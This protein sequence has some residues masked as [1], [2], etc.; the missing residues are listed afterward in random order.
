MSIGEPRRP[1][2]PVGRPLS[3]Y[4]TLGF[5]VVGVGL[6]L[7][8]LLTLSG[9]GGGTHAAATNTRQDDP[10]EEARDTLDHS[11]DVS[12]CRAALQKINLAL[13]REVVPRA[14]PLDPKEG[15][16]LQKDFN[17]SKEE[18]EEISAEN[19]TLLDG[20]HLDGAFLLHDAATH[21]LEPEEVGGDLPAPSPLERATAA[22]AWVMREVRLAEPTPVGLT[23]PQFALRRA[24]GT[25]LERALVYLELLDQLGAA[26]DEAAAKP[27]QAE[28]PPLLGCLIFCRDKPAD[29][30]RLWACGVVLNGGPD[31]YLFDPRLGLPLPGANGKSVATL[32]EVCKDASLLKQLDVDAAHPYDVTTEQA[33]TAELHLVCSLSSLAPRMAHLQKKLL[34]PVRVSL[35]HDLNGEL[36]IW[37]NAA[38]KTEGVSPP[39][40]VWAEGAGVLRRFLPADDGGADPGW[41]GGFPLAALVGFTNPND[42]SKVQMQRL[43]LFRLQMA[44]WD[45]MPAQFHDM[46]K[47]PYNVGLGLRV[48]EGFLAPFAHMMAEPQ[49]PRDRMLRGEFDKAAGD[50]VGMSARMRLHLD[51]REAAGTAGELE[52]DV[53]A[54]VDKA[55]HAYAD[56]LRAQEKGSP[57]AVE[58]ATREVDAIWKE[59]TPVVTLL[60][61]ASAVPGLADA[62][63]LLGLCKHEKAEQSQTRLDLLARS[64]GDKAKESDRLKDARQDAR[65]AWID[66]LGWWKKYGDDHPEESPQRPSSSPGR[67]AAVRQM[68]ARAQAMLGDDKAAQT[69]Y[70][71]LTEPMAPLEKVAALYRARRMKR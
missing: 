33:R 53:D 21:A 3:F 22:F 5:L 44:P 4:I 16:R 7:M 34:P 58:A 71:D 64:L 66:A 70:E 29:A 47:F 20:Q 27:G 25:P 40:K 59:A 43:Q 32:A 42:P 46:E 26:D 36:Q 41:P 8:I 24:T 69:T 15:E 2:E 50:L 12:A 31:V 49:S 62:T 17:L 18:I 55:R 56:Q 52:K 23:P 38:A 19:Y 67:A 6:V 60:E 10:L 35:S 37:K 1:S 63:Y 54:W 28:T 11:P 57:A 68:R 9:F 61:G 51:Q 13:S 39:V 48:R 30:P 45:V 14:A 65:T